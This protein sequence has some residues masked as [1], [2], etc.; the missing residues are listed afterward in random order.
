MKRSKLNKM[1]D[2]L[3]A[4][5]AAA[6]DEATWIKLGLRTTTSWDIFADSFVTSRAD[7]NIM[8]FNEVD[9]IAGFSM[10]Y[11]A[12]M[13]LVRREANGGG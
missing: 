12:A 9:F 11:A 3:N 8:T 5:F 2:K 10:G 4:E 6:V 13:E 1:A 7:G